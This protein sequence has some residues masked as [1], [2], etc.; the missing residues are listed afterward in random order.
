M[1]FITQLNNAWLSHFSEENPFPRWMGFPRQQLISTQEEFLDECWRYFAVNDIYTS[2]Y[3]ESAK[4]ELDDAPALIVDKLY[5]DV[6]APTTP[7]KEIVEGGLMK[8]HYQMQL[9]CDVLHEVCGMFPRVYFSGR[10]GFA[11]YADIQPMVITYD[12][13]RFAA[14]RL[15]QNLLAAAGLIRL[16]NYNN[17]GWELFDP[18]VIGCVGQI[19][20]MP[21]TIH[22]LSGLTCVPIDPV[23]SLD[24]CLQLAKQTKPEPI[25]INQFPM[26]INQHLEDIIIEEYPEWL[27]K[28]AEYHKTPQSLDKDLKL[29]LELAPHLKD[30]WSRTIHAMITP[31]AVMLGWSRDKIHG[32]CKQFV[33][34]S[35][36][37]Y[38]FDR[39]R[40]VDYQITYR[41]QGAIPWGWDK[42][43][44]TFPDLHG[45]FTR[46]GAQL[47]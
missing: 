33:E 37:P 3:P 31:R 14:R 18:S 34:A 10:K 46:A 6:D 2:V 9:F 41:K 47:K 26:I 13:F 32:Y 4:T 19:S 24:E 27:A 29:L 35:G 17:C 30:G 44:H 25:E 16:T 28:Q 21:Y 42:F 40:E 20:R 15:T 43:F 45:V 12:A 22:I 23:L 5:W 8:A 39:R 1:K 11:I 7:Q 36:Q 38:N